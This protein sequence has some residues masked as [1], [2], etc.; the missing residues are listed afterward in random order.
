[1]QVYRQRQDAEYISDFDREIK[2][3]QGPTKD[4]P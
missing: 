3:L 4:Q 2:R 1:M